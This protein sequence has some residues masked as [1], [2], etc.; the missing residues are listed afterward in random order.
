MNYSLTRLGNQSFLNQNW[1][2]L[3]TEPVQWEPHYIVVVSPDA[4]HQGASK[5]LN[6][7][8]TSLVPEMPPS[9]MTTPCISMHFSYRSF[10]F[11]LL[12]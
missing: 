5:T 11:Q 3:Q 4:L 12:N 7:I 6:A 10:Q 1:G 2:K 8:S 9:C